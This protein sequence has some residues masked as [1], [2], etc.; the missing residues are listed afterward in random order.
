MIR[1]IKWWA[2]F[3]ATAGYHELTRGLDQS[4]YLPLLSTSNDSSPAFSSL[5]R[6]ILGVVYTQ[7]AC[8]NHHPFSNAFLPPTSP[9]KASNSDVVH[10]QPPVPELNDEGC[11]IGIDVWESK[12]GLDS[13]A[14]FLDLSAK[15]MEVTGRTDPLFNQEWRDAVKLALEVCR[16]QQRGTDEEAQILGTPW[17]GPPRHELGQQEPS[18]S[19]SNAF[20][21]HPLNGARGVYRFT[22]STRASSETR[23]L[24]GL[25]EPARRC[26][27]IKSAFRPSDDATVLPFL[28]PSNAFFVCAARR[29]AELMK[30]GVLADP[31]ESAFVDAI[32]QRLRVSAELESLYKELVHLSSSVDTSLKETAIVKLADGEQ[33]YAYEVDGFGA[34]ALR[35]SGL[36]QLTDVYRLL[37]SG[38]RCELA[39]FAITTASGFRFALRH[40]IHGDAPPH[41]FEPQ[42]MVLQRQRRRGCRR[43]AYR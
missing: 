12:W 21:D 11:R 32:E 26:G 37:S 31:P 22:R 27:L 40:R 6:L 43:H 17:Y 5:Y 34:F 1:L 2:H 3:Q 41:L 38:G 33:V 9:I 14:S 18:A 7:A 15:L 42:Q 10:P 30:D 39:V 35:S 8:I 16:L 4:A 13:I 24:G 25:G 36:H 20:S 29:L 28:V 19:A 23:G